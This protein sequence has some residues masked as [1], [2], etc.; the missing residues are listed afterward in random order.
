MST[1]IGFV[2]RPIIS[3]SV[4]TVL[5]MAR[6]R[7]EAVVDLLDLSTEVL[8]TYRITKLAGSQAVNVAT[9]SPGAQQSNNL[10]TDTR[11]Q[12]LLVADAFEQTIPCLGLSAEHEDQARAEVEQLRQEVAQ[13][14]A[15][16]S[17]LAKAL[18]RVKSLAGKGTSVAAS[19]GITLLVQQAAGSLPWG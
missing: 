14:R 12:V 15:D 3:R 17:R 11:R 7:T 8:A 16:P 13:Q 10:T 4:G 6:T 19:A 5:S 18:Q 1:L 9:N 2:M